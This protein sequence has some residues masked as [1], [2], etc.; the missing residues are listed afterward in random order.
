MSSAPATPTYAARSAGGDAV[1]RHQIVV[2]A[3]WRIR[4]HTT[5]ERDFAPV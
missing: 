1:E 3:I 5:L 2:L 4:S